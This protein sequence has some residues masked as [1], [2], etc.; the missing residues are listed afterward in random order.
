[1]R[2][3]LYL[4]LIIAAV[5]IGCKASSGNNSS[6]QTDSGEITV[7]F[8]PWSEPPKDILDKFQTDSKVKVNLNIMGWDQIHD[9]ITIAAASKTAP[10]DVIEVDW[11]WVTEFKKSDCIEPLVVDDATKA[12]F[13]LFNSFTVEGV[14]VAFPYLNDFRMGFYNTE[15]L[16]A[17]GITTPPATWD[18]LAADAVKIKN[19]GK[20]TYPLVF[21]TSPT[22]TTTTQFFWL[23]MSRTGEFFKP[24]GT[25]NRDNVLASLNFIDNALKNLK[26][27]DPAMASMNDQESGQVFFN[28][29]A[30]FIIGGP[31]GLITAD[32][33]E[34]S[35]VVGKIQPMLIPGGNGI[36]T[37]T[38]ALPGGAGIAKYSKN[39]ISARKFIDWYVS[40]D[41]QVAMF[42]TQGNLP[43]NLQVFGK[44]VKE[45][46]IHNGNVAL[47][48]AGTTK[49]PFPLGIPDWYAEF[50]SEFSNQVNRMSQGGATPDQVADIIETRV[51]EYMK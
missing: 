20:C 49:S 2:K 47:E 38:F 46:L 43:A 31:G 44:L 19:T 51:N 9:K 23:T 8:P 15:L 39:K 6:G 10:A 34:I 12:N 1:M 41:A 7:L 42:N 30:A 17:A 5:I 32:N 50:S 21:I 37:S 45:D 16:N 22:E 24:N 48:Q 18:E 28:G 35:K 33:P 26:I 4:V 27:I 13:P 3:T 40:E 29:D 14:V 36:K 11:S 25:L